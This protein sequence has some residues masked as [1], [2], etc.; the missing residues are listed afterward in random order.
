M[1]KIKTIVIIKEKLNEIL[2]DKFKK[3]KKHNSK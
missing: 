1:K 2:Q 3:N